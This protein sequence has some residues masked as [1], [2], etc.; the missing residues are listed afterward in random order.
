MVD[1]TSFTRMNPSYGGFNADSSG[2]LKG[3]KTIP[4]DKKFQV[5]QV[6]KLKYQTWPTVCGFS[7]SIK[8]WGEIVVEN[9]SG[10]SNG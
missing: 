9:T 3:I 6:P 5:S 2:A 10:K 4:T 1:G 7:F 8:K